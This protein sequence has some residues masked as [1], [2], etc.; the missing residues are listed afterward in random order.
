MRVFSLSI[1]GNGN[2]SKS[3]EEWEFQTLWKGISLQYPDL[4]FLSAISNTGQVTSKLETLF[5]LNNR[6]SL[7]F[8]YD[9]TSSLSVGFGQKWKYERNKKCEGRRKNVSKSI[10]QHEFLPI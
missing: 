4:G 2:I 3:W 1:T 5:M 9:P 6:K 8:R 7:E 10:E